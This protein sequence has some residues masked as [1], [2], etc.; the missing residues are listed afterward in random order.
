MTVT[1]R[2][3][4][5]M[6]ALATAPVRAQPMREPTEMRILQ[7]PHPTHRQEVFDVPVPDA[8]DYRLFRAL[9]R[10]DP[11]KQGWPSLWLLDG[12]AAFDRMN[13][14]LLAQFPDLAVIGIGYPTNLPFDTTRRALDYTPPPLRTDPRRPERQVGGADL[15]MARLS[16][17]LRQR[18]EADARFDPSRRM[19]AGHS[20]GGLFVLYALSTSGSGFSR[21]AAISPALWLTGTE[22]FSEFSRLTVIVGDSE[23][24][25]GA[26][27][28][29]ALPAHR[30]PAPAQRLVARAKAQGEPVSLHVLRGMQHGE[31]LA[32]AH[33]LLMQLATSPPGESGDP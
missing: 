22:E 8:Q 29:P 30:I 19:L 12:N 2:S 11:E 5:A 9:P 27:A 23:R 13:P 17:V 16:G 31:T 10:T 4:L 24:E 7:A 28:D 33:P 21:F 20:Y 25:R 32:G 18:A 14:D 26:L 3:V 15:F 6:A 1:R